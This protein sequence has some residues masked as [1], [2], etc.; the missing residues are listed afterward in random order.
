MHKWLMPWKVLGA[1]EKIA[2]AFFTSMERPRRTVQEGVGEEGQTDA[3]L[4]ERENGVCVE[5]PKDLAICGMSLIRTSRRLNL[6]I[7]PPHSIKHSVHVQHP[8]RKFHLHDPTIEAICLVELNV[9]AP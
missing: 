5:S 9:F 7:N 3:L 2:E 8:M 1:R 4:R 6:T